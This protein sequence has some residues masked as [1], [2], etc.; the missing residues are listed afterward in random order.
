MDAPT[1]DKKAAP[2]RL[3]AIYDA[4]LS[5][6]SQ[7]LNTLLR[8]ADCETSTLSLFASCIF[9]AILQTLMTDLGQEIFFA[10][11]PEAFHSNYL[12]SERFLDSLLSCAPTPSSRQSAEAHPSLEQF[13]KRWQVSVYFQMRLRQI[14]GFYETELAD[15]E[16]LLPGDGAAALMRGT[17]ATV[18]A[19]STPWS[20]D[21]HLDIL[22]QREWRLCLQICSRYKTWLDQILPD[23]PSAKGLPTHVRSDSAGGR[24]SGEFRGTPRTASPH[25]TPE[26][27]AA[28]DDALLRAAVIAAD[29]IFL[30][31]QLLLTFEQKVSPRVRSISGDSSSEQILAELRASLERSIPLRSSIVPGLSRVIQRILAARC[32]EPLRMVRQ[33]STQYRSNN[34]RHA[35]SSSAQ[36]EPS[37]FV[38]QIFHPLLAFFSSEEEGVLGTAARRLDAE[39]K[40]E[41]LSSV[42]GDTLEKYAAA[43]FSMNQT[44]ESLRR[45]KRS[46]QALGFAS[47]LFGSGGG[48]SGGSGTATPDTTELDRQRIQMQADAQAVKADALAA[49]AAAGVSLDVEALPAW[50]RLLAA[51][52]GATEE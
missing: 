22:L 40:R 45:L 44:Q 16:E 33:I 5:L 17:E 14:V 12:L 35:R 32:A 43:L 28:D 31:R 4:I 3:S 42:V 37:S 18:S 51:A 36:I 6:V 48:G 1:A 11:R 41:L 24:A 27:S 20:D 49:A 21:V 38:P 13:R 34:A 19:F 29:L 15:G 2:S 30:E 7:D 47:S 23:L 52:A 10:G 46:N 50:K 39:T 8:V 26:D 9:P 25:P